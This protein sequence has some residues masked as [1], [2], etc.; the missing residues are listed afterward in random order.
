MSE[1]TQE[2]RCELNNIRH[3]IERMEKL[4]TSEKLKAVSAVLRGVLELYSSNFVLA[5]ARYQ[6]ER[7]CQ[8]NME[9]L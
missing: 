1:L 6:L 5:N 7:C 9:R 3:E 8:N 2:E 4:T